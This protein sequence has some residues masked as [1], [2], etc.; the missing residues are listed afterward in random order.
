QPGGSGTGTITAVEL[1]VSY[2]DGTTWQ[3][4]TLTPGDNDRHT[5]TLTLP[6]NRDGFIALRAAAQTD[7]GFAIRQEIIRAYGLR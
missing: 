1:E 2:D 4:V 3:P 6:K 5:G 7:T